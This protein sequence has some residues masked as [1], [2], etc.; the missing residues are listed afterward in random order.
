MVLAPC[1]RSDWF[2]PASTRPHG[3]LWAGST[4]NKEFSV[5]AQP[6]GSPDSRG[7]GLG[8]PRRG[9]A[10]QFPDIWVSSCAQREVGAQ[11]QEAEVHLLKHL[12]LMFLKPSQEPGSEATL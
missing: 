3:A 1:K 4:G 12:F 8:V 9:P 7:G 2:F 6:K 10:Q 5:R 11:E